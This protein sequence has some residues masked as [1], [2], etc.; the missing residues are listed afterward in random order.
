MR[1]EKLEDIKISSTVLFI[2]SLIGTI[3][4]VAAEIDA[5]KY[6]KASFIWLIII[7][8]IFTIGSLV[9]A[10]VSSHILKKRQKDTYWSVSKYFQALF[11]LLFP[12]MVSSNSVK[13]KKIN[14]SN[15]NKQTNFWKEMC[16]GYYRGSIV[17]FIFWFV[18][19]L[20]CVWMIVSAV[21]SSNKTDKIFDLVSFSIAAVIVFAVMI[22]A[23]MGIKKD[24]TPIFE[25]MDISKVKFN[26]I[27]KHYDSAEKI[28]YDI[29]VDRKY[30]Y[31]LSNG[32]AY[33][34][35]MKEYEDIQISFSR[36]R[37]IMVLTSTYN[38]VVK[39]AFLPM[40]FNKAKRK[41]EEIYNSME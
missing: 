20:S 34:I 27:A 8:L 15:K 21:F 41:I 37:F 2:I 29:W 22:V 32:K 12:S 24:P 35:P 4:F 25:Y 23:A 36:F 10:I 38:C 31:L 17:S 6:G 14:V 28:A 18:L 33:C 13:L 16:T 19:F 11:E 7:A 9:V 30:I 5:I 26:E 39:S 1:N 40:K 3:M